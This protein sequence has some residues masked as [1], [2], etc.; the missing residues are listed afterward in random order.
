MEEGNVIGKGK[1]AVTLQGV[2]KGEE[3]GETEEDR[4]KGER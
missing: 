4:K 1:R 3:K 2:R